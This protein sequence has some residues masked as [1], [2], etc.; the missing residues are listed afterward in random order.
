M[1]LDIYVQTFKN[2]YD[3]AHVTFMLFSQLTCFTHYTVA[4]KNA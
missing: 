2:P 3:T 1:I 4:F